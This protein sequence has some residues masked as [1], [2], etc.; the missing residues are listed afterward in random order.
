V[1]VGRQN[2]ELL[3]VLARFLAHAASNHAS[4]V[5]VT[6]KPGIKTTIFMDRAALQTSRQPTNQQ[7]Q[8]D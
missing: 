6:Q 5:N 4:N 3:P 1:T 2:S 7:E 8:P